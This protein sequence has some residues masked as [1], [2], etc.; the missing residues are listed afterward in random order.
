MLM[1]ERG[2]DSGKTVN[3]KDGID[4]LYSNLKIIIILN[5]TL[6][7]DGLNPWRFNFEGSNGVPLKGDPYAFQAFFKDSSCDYY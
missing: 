1:E 3:G 2:E 6:I 5:K 4:K 7:H